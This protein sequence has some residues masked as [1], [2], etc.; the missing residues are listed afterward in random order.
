MTGALVSSLLNGGSGSG[1]GISTKKVIIK[2]A[3]LPTASEKTLGAMYIYAGEDTADLKHGYI[4]EGRSIAANTKEVEFSTNTISCSGTNFWELVKTL[5]PS[6]YTEI[7]KGEMVLVG[8]NTWRIVGR[9]TNDEQVLSYQQYDADFESAGF[10]F[11]GTFSEGDTVPF[12]CEINE[13]AVTQYVWRRIDVQPSSSKGQVIAVD[14]ELSPTSENPVQNKAIANALGV[15]WVKPED[16]PDICSGALPN[17]VYFLVGH[18]ADYQTYPKFGVFA[19]TTSGTGTYDVYV[20]GIKQ[21]TTATNTNTVLDWA[22]LALTSGRT[23]SYPSALTTHIVRI[24][25]TTSTDT[26]SICNVDATNI[27]SKPMGVLWAHF[28]LTNTISLGKL[29]NRGNAEAPL[30]EAATATN[31]TITLASGAYSVENLFRVCPSLQYMPLLDMST[32]T[33]TLELS[34]SND[35]DKLKRLRI[36]GLKETLQYGYQFRGLTGLEHLEADGCVI[37]VGPASFYNCKKLKKLNVALDWSG[38][39]AVSSIFNNCVSLQETF[40]DTS[41]ATGMTQ[42]G[43][44]GS[45]ASP[46]LGIKGVVVSPQAPFSGSSPQL[47]V[48]YTGLDRFALINLFNSMPYNVGYET[49]GSPTITN[50]VVSGFSNSNYL[51]IN[52]ISSANSIEININ[53]TINNLSTWQ[54]IFRCSVSQNRTLEI[55]GSNGTLRYY[56]LA[57]NGTSTNIGDISGV[58]A[59][60]PVNCNLQ[61]SGT[62][63]K[64]IITQNNTELFNTTVN[65]SNFSDL[66]N[67]IW[68]GYVGKDVFL[69]SIDLNHTYIKVNGVPWFRGTA[70]MTKT[71][72]VR[73]CTGTADLTQTDKD[74]ALDKGWSLTVA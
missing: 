19:R 71:C 28:S 33:G 41:A 72:D 11:N 39:T 36:K 22:T 46:L 23:V 24:T 20:D 38:A 34:S 31:D 9:N 35:K 21:A 25:P 47:N 59:N 7:V 32:V 42:L 61:A 40:L 16:W 6:N 17:S 55:N 3:T 14:T 15:D 43:L 66:L 67:Q 73:G 10:T 63:L 4:Y 69:G 26:L 57:T 12:V 44:G 64:V 53:A 56:Y 2:S 74:I 29:F 70:A 62:T 30:V 37:K 50:G 51:Y 13:T 5:A 48:S 18:S 49:V 27:T 65:D 8:G 45:S 54:S 1:G 60:V 58:V 68:F 52:N